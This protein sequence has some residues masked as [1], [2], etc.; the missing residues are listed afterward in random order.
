M[1]DRT[2]S[3]HAQDFHD[4]MHALSDG[5]RAYRAL[6]YETPEFLPYFRARPWIAEIAELNS[7][8]GRHRAG[9]RSASKTCAFLGIQLSQC[10]LTLP[11]WYGFGT[12]V[13]AYGRRALGAR[14]GRDAARHA[15]ALAA[16]PQHVEHE[17]GAGEDRPAIAS[18]TRPGDRCGGA[19]SNLPETRGRAPAYVHWLL[20]VTGQTGL[21]DDNPTLAR[22]RNRFPY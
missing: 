9:H 18:A 10:R 16:L 4:A 14:R 22:I 15:P 20:Q 8:A 19:R 5:I 17:H 7:A 13:E 2:E 1:R 6:V 11:G 3:D 12:A 21:P